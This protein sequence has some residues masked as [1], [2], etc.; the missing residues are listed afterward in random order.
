VKAYVLIRQAPWY[1][2]QS[3]IDGLKAAGHEVF[4]SLPSKFDSDS[5]AVIWN[6]YGSGEALAS[7]VE[8][9]GGTVLVSEN[10]YLGLRGVSPK[11]SVHNPKGS[12]PNDY[13]ALGLGYQ[14][15]ASRVKVGGPERWEA[16][17]LE[18]KPWRTEGKHVLICPNRSFGA[19]G[20]VMDP[21]WAEM[22]AFRVRQQTNREVRIRLHPGNDAP[23]RPISEDLKDCWAVF[24]WSSSVASHSLLAGIPTYIE[25]PFQILKGASASGPVEAPQVVDRLE[26]FQRLSWGQWQV[27]EIAQGLPFRHLLP[28]PAMAL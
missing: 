2:R 15:D 25:A 1:R 11:F 14:N 7:K 12:A 21:K 10:G 20:R 27:A 18:L 3:F 6:R 22:C 13:Y 16:M 23:K 5:V 8:A 19:P 24:V 17:G 4:E 26:H 28:V 9:D